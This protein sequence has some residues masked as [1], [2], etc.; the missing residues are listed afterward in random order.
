MSFQGNLQRSPVKYISSAC[1]P[2][3]TFLPSAHENTNLPEER[4]KHLKF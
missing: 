1:R 2:R 3:V 4:S